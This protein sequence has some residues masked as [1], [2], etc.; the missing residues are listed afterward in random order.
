MN[1]SSVFLHLTRLEM[2]VY[3]GRSAFSVDFIQSTLPVAAALVRPLQFLFP[4]AIG[5]SSLRYQ[6]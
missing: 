3:G 5:G 4:G 6:R 1:S 2:G